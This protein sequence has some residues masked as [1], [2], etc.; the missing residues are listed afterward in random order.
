M[1]LLLFPFLTAW[2]Y[3]MQ[4]IKAALD[5]FK[6][7]CSGRRNR[8]LLKNMFIRLLDT[9]YIGFEKFASRPA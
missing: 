7:E 3:T 9:P 2:N 6:Q 8:Y 1:R 5:D 4:H